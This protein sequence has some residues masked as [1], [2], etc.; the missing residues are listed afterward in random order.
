M[1]ATIALLTD[2]GTRDTYVGVMKG[3]MQRITPDV[4]FIDI[5][6][7][8]QPQNIRQSAF[9]LLNSYRYF[10][11]GTIFLVVV[12]PGVGST[13]KPIAAQAGDYT[14]V[15]P[16]NGLLSEVLAEFETVSAVELTNPAYQLTPVSNT[17]HGRDIF[18]PAAAHLAAG[19]PLSEFG[20]TTKPVQKA[21][22][23][24]LHIEGSSIRGEILY[25]DH[26]GNMV[27]SIGTL[28]WSD[29]RHLTLT[30]RFGGGAGQS[31][32]I[33]AQHA[34]LNVKNQ[35][36]TGIRRTYSEVERQQILLLVGSSGFLEIAMNQG[37]ATQHLSLS[38]GDP[39]E[40]QIG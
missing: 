33:D 2:F 16:D 28:R 40:L 36:I 11:P 25:A 6:H 7:D 4:R 30:S 35:I 24:P 14:F 39:V 15:A 13:R 20:A 32:I 10:A 27:T 3:V 18:A 31:P 9:A 21:L 19:V 8:I 37:S 38:S 23:P 22:L 1:N 26:F 5:S 34:I 29:E 17:F 12:D